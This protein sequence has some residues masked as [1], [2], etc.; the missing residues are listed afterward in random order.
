MHS[1]FVPGESDRTQRRDWSAAHFF[2]LPCC[3][4]S[5]IIIISFWDTSNTYLRGVSWGLEWDQNH[6]E[7]GVSWQDWW[8]EGSLPSSLSFSNQIQS[9]LIADIVH[10][11]LLAMVL[12]VVNVRECESENTSQD[13]TK[14]GQTLDL[15]SS[16]WYTDSICNLTVIGCIRMGVAN[17]QWAIIDHPHSFHSPD[18]EVSQGAEIWT[19]GSTC[20]SWKSSGSTSMYIYTYVQIHHLS[21]KPTDFCD[22]LCLI[23]LLVI[24]C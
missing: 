10:F 18:A 21:S 22:I 6:I 1:F 15:L 20:T 24:Q 11:W 17:S 4:G 14:Q 13:R 16:P 3:Q 8:L 5:G 23:W 19:Q 2:H 12:Q 9:L 7:Y